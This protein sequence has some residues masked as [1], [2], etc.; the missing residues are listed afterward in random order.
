LPVRDADDPADLRNP[1]PL[2]AHLA[3]S[4]PQTGITTL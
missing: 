1:I 3:R 4:E 2:L